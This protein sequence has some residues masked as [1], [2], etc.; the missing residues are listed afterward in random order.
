MRDCWKIFSNINIKNIDD[1][2]QEFSILTEFV[3]KIF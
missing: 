2:Y 3:F 1:Y